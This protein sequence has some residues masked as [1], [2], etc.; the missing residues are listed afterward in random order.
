MAA[1]SNVK[2]SAGGANYEPLVLGHAVAGPMALA[3]AGEAEDF[4]VG[5]QLRGEAPGADDVVARVWLTGRDG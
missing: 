4:R 5:T 3:A 1:N 2:L